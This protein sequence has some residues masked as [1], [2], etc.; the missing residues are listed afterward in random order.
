MSV[1]SKRHPFSRLATGAFILHSG[2]D[3]FKADEE[4]AAGLHGFAT[5]AYPF[6]GKLEPQ[7]FAKLLAAGETAVGA[8]LLLPFVPNR[9]AGAALSG[10]AG[11][12]VGLYARAPGLREP[13]SIWPTQD[14]IA[15]AKDT[16]LL[17]IGVDLLLDRQGGSDHE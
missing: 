13:G 4:T 17:G 14:G 12:L 7:Q 2:L 6:L 5:T 3:K 10:L 1:I 15:V 8:V 9:V 16:W 11:G